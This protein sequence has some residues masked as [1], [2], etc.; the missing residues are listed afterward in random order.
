MNEIKKL[1]QRLTNV[2]K[3]TV[4]YRMTVAEARQLLVEV[5][6]LSKPIVPA[7]IPETDVVEIRQI[8]M[9]GGTF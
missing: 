1:R 2:G 9:D 7:I 4:E 6:E 8:I 5:E 3:N